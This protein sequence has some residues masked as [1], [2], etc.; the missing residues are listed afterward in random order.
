M[1]GRVGVLTR[2]CG[3]NSVIP[4]ASERP[5][6]GSEIT[7]AR[8]DLG[9]VRDSHANQALAGEESH[10]NSEAANHG[11]G[12]RSAPDDKSG[13]GPP[14]SKSWRLHLLAQPLLAVYLFN[15][16]NR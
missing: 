5:H 10:E 15:D 3:S 13:R 2:V 16:K 6:F 14:Q 1:S 9:Q 7:Q 4:S 11:R 8:N 12:P